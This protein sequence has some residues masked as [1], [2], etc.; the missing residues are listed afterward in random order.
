[1]RVTIKTWQKPETAL[2]KSLAPRVLSKRN[3][4]QICLNIYIF[5]LFL[6]LLLHRL[7]RISLPF[8]DFLQVIIVLI[9][10]C[11]ASVTV[12][13]APPPPRNKEGGTRVK[14]RAKNGASKRALVSFLARPK[15]RILFLGLSLLRNHR[16]G[17]ADILY[18]LHAYSS[19]FLATAQ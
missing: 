6:C 15:P 11:V 16:H 13:F 8:Y 17:L 10:A 1:M 5:V 2:E 9:L 14:D 18:A 3:I 7:V 19:S 12:R 4:G